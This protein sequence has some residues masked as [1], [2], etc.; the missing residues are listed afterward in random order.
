MGIQR[1]IFFSIHESEKHPEVPLMAIK[2][3]TEQFLEQTTL[4]YTNIRLCG[5]MQ[6]LIGQYAVPI[7]EE[8]SVWGTDATTRIAY[9]D[10]QDVARMT[11]AALR[12]EKTYRTTFTLA[13]PRAWTTQEVIALCE[14]YAGQDAKVT[15]V[16]AGVLKATRKLTQ[17][18]Q[19]TADVAD[20]LA[21]SEVLTSN[22]VFSAPMTETYK[23]LGLDPKDTSTL[24]QY[25]QEYYSQILK[26]LKDLKATSKQ[27]DYY[28]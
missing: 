9:L 4:N 20:R 13:G 22:A 12:N 7:L 24:E 8:Q 5:F 23:M 10:S 17:L 14:R 27:G 15:T 11:M 2:R 3:C 26:K 16:P 28:L 21:F 1:Y 6:A 18:F 19:W 25:L